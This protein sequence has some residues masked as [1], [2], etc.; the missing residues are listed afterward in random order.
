MRSQ[1]A[2]LALH[3]LDRSGEVPPVGVPGDRPQGL[4]LAAAPD[5]DRK[6]TRAPNWKWAMTERPEVVATALRA[7]HLLTAQEGGDRGHGLVEPIEPIAEAAAEVDPVGRVLVLEPGAAEPE[8]GSAAG[9]VVDR[10]RR[11]GGQAGVTEGVGAD[12]E[13]E[14]RT[15]GHRGPG[16]Q[17]G[18]ALEDVLVRVAHDRVEVV[19]GPERVQPGGVGGAGGVAQLGDFAIGD[20]RFRRGSGASPGW[21]GLFFFQPAWWG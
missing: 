11:L 2:D 10:D 1:D 21:M 14:V 12:H 4:L 7:R 6:A 8:P 5:H 15:L 18:R 3:L 20:S 16:S 13:P 9:D 17:Q 19:P